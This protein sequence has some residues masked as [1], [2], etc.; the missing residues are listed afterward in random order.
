MKSKKIVLLFSASLVVALFF[1][2]CNKSDPNSPTSLDKSS[3][4]ILKANGKTATN[5]NS[6]ASA[7]GNLSLSTFNISL[8]KINIQENSGFDG[9][10]TGENNDGGSNNGDTEA[11]DILLN[12]P[13]TFNIASGSVDVGTFAVYPG[14]FKQ[15]D[16]N[17][18]TDVNPPFNG[19]SLF[20]NGD[21]VKSNGNVIPFVLQ[22]KFSNTFQTLISGTGITVTQNSTVPVTIMFDFDKMFANI[23]FDS[24]TITNGTI[25]ID[26]THNTG[27]LQSFE[28]NLN[29][30]V[31]LED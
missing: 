4:V 27:L 21:F 8:S 28:N 3:T 7:N 13:F 30:S 9:E 26:E 19:N 29:N 15:V 16:L 6:I 23:N 31:E 12:G 24:T 1:S 10:Q 17:F 25:L 11:P 5:I 22:S 2:A 20:V 14:T 18:F